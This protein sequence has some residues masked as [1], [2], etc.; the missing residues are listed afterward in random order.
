LTALLT[1]RDHEHLN[2]A[3][4]L[5]REAGSLGNLP[6]GCVI[7]LD[8][9]IVSEGKNAIYQPRLALDRHAELEAL[10]AL[11][12]DVRPRLAEM[13]LYTTLEPCLMCAAAIMLHGIG[14]VVFGSTDGFGGLGAT[15]GHLPPFF[16]QQYAASVWTGP[17]DSEECD[18]L[19]ERV[20]ELER[21]RGIEM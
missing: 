4:E 20:K 19:Y 18:A 17:A 21:A 14:R 3:I 2:R 15:A 10:R 9:R 13:T 1:D 11:P 12:D 16:V 6:I 5:A 7:C 8:D